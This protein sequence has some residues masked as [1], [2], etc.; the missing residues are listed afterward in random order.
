MSEIGKVSH[1]V[2]AAIGGLLPAYAHRDDMP[3][4]GFVWTW[5]TTSGVWTLEWLGFAQSGERNWG[6]RAQP[7]GQWTLPTFVHPDA[8]PPN[9]V[10]P[11]LVEFLR[12]LGAI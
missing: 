10:P 7:G 2:A 9:R 6:V 1:Q 12:L 5:T 4:G 8:P 11:V 3:A